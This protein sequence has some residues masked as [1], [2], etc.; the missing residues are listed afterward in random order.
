MVQL[1][2]TVCAVIAHP[3]GACR[4]SE[5][6]WVGKD[7]VIAIHERLLADYGG[8]SG[9]RDLGLLESALARPQQIHVHDDPDFAALASAYAAGIIHNHSFVD[10]NKRV[11][12]MAAYV[13]LARNALN[14]T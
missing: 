12:F 4:V 2:K 5:P 7:V 14:R 8:P 11:G 13:F 1:P 10:R 6:V 3:Q 9:I